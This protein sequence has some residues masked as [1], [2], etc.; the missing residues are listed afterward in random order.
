MPLW[1]CLRCVLLLLWAGLAYAHEP[2]EEGAVVLP[3]VPVLAER[4]TAASSEHVIPG[5]D[6]LL[7]PQGRPGNLLRLAPGI[8][9]VEHSGGAGKADQ[10]FLR[11]FDA[12]HGTDIAVFR[13]GMPINLR[14]NAHGQ[15]Y[16]DLNFIIP[17]TIKE[18][19]VYKGPYHVQYGDFDT[20]AAVEFVTRET[21]EEGI[22][23]A[24]GG[25]FNQQRYMTMFSPP[26]GKVRTLVAA[27][28]YHMDGPF[29]SANRY[30]RFNGLAKVT[31]NPTGR[32][33]LSLTGTYYTGRWNA[34]G[35]IPLQL[36][37]DGQ[38]NRFGSLDPSEGGRTQRGTATLRYHYDAPGGGRF[39]ADLYG[40]YY[41][42]DLYSNFTFFLNDPVNGDGIEQN[43][44]RFVYG[45]DVGYRQAGDLAGVASAAT[46]GVQ[47]RVDDIQ[48]RLGTQQRRMRLGTISDSDVMEAS[49]S[50]YLK[51]EFQPM[52]WMRINGG[53][54]GDLYTFTVQNR[55]PTCPQ[56]PNGQTDAAIASTKGNLVLGPWFGTEF[57]LNFG[58]GFHSNDARAVVSN[59][60][61]Q[62]L[63]RATAYEVGVRTKQ[64]DRAEL[65]ATL[66]AMDLSSE[67]VYTGDTGT[68]EIRGATRRYGTELGARLQLLE[69]LSLRGDLTLTHAE[70]RGTGQA[71]PLAPEMTGQAGLTAT[72]ENG[73]T[74]SLQMLHMG[75]RPANED[76]SVYLQG[77]TVFDWVNR[78][79]V[80]VKM[81]R[82]R[83]EAFFTIQNLFDAQWRQ[84]QFFYE[85]RV[86]PSAAA[87]SDI[88]FSPGMPRNVMG[89]I[90]WLF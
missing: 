11:G 74:S 34:S 75:K 81:E 77:F 38:L 39:F 73:L 50:P 83:V 79:R 41:K 56:Q 55:C 80:S 23:Q 63:P 17:E 46:L 72:L 84:A 31:M 57:F 22:V 35:Q 71:V 37:N 66:W 6:I 54:R 69:W 36:V 24:A 18:V 40:Q 70:F 78:Y 53:A 21:V 9:T 58:T 28:G 89:G 67:L 47:T 3:D 5:K 51:L 49:Y 85:S 20:G 43:D 64:W 87:V 44:R 76:R 48:V 88:H 19:Q 42:L 86:S 30:S 8:L 45:S 59:P 65:L 2:A 13:D 82:G 29:L 4:L 33:E 60:A 26:T 25:Q 14:S 10:Y 15:G 68:T 12:D 90:A 62:T 61:V 27:E 32:S 1:C 52:P 7:Q 16:T